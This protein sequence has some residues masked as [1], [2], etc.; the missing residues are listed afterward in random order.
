MYRILSVEE[1]LKY[2]KELE[3]FFNNLDYNVKQDIKSLLSPYIKKI[4]CFHDFYINNESKCVCRH[5]HLEKPVDYIDYVDWLNSSVEFFNQTA[6]QILSFGYEIITKQ[7]LLELYSDIKISYILFQ[8]NITIEEYGLYSLYAY[9]QK[10]TNK[11]H[12][13]YATTKAFRDSFSEDLKIKI[14]N[15]LGDYKY[16]TWM[17]EY[18]ANLPGE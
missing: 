6:K 2:E 13:I 18:F 17:E 7:S 9:C 12:P 16:I 14:K 10:I 11:S 1:S 3:D 8:N 15:I 4:N 5:C